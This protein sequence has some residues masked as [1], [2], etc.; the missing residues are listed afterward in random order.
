M[1]ESGVRT[2]RQDQARDAIPILEKALTVSNRRPRRNRC[3][4]PGVCSHGASH[5]CASTAG[6][7]PGTQKKCYIPAPAFVNAYLGFGEKDEAFASLEQAYN[8][9]SNILQFLKVHPCLDPLRSDPRFAELA[10]CVGCKLKP[11][12]TLIAVHRNVLD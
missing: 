7:T 8:Q 11:A 6:R 2:N 1:A 12:R 5:R 9:Q 4:Y 3:R 10:R